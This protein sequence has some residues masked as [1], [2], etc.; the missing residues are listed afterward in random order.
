MLVET[1]PQRFWRGYPLQPQRLAEEIVLSD[2]GDRFEVA[3]AQTHQPQIALGYV[4][5]GDAV[6]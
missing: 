4:F 2:V 3:L 5:M 1:L 6:A